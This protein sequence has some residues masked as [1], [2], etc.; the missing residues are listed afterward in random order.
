[1]GAAVA[2]HPVEVERQAALLVLGDRWDVG[3]DAVNVGPDVL[4]RLIKLADKARAELGDGKK[5]GAGQRPAGMVE[6]ATPRL[7]S[8]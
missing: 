8:K 7:L 5:P 2:E 1:M 6:K 4:A 3:G